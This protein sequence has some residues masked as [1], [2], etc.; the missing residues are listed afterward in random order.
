[1]ETMKN[2]FG[3]KSISTAMIAFV[4][5]LA[6]CSKTSDSVL[7]STDNQNVNSESASD[8]YSD[9][10]T[11]VSNIAI[12]GVTDLQYAGARTEGDSVTRLKNIDDRLK[13]ATV[14][15]TRTPNST[16]DNPVGSIVIDFGTG[17]TDSRNVTRKG[18]IIISY[19][20]RRFYPGSKV[21]TTFDG[22]FRNDVK[23]EGTHTLTNVTASLTSNV[24]FTAVIVGGKITF[25]D[26]KTITREQTFTREWQ[27]GANP[28]LDKWLILSGST[29]SGTNKNGKS[30]TMTVTADLVYSRACAISNKVFMPVSGTKVFV[31]DGKSYSVDFG[32]GDCDNDVTVTVNGAS[33]TITVGADGN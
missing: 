25:G 28:L 23:V 5:I 12:G 33:K 10:A 3:L 2:V 27:R 9:E 6:S 32:K 7:S 20:G 26:G 30:Y 1:M 24:K 8:S 16:K 22:Y 29:A 31:V 11:D 17:C 13:C 18:K 19:I 4:L 21:T 14:T 15:I